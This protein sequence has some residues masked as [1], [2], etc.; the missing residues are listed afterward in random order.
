MGRKIWSKSPTN[1]SISRL[2]P[3]L[4][5]KVCQPCI[6][7]SVYACRLC[8]GV[9]KAG[10]CSHMLGRGWVRSNLFGSIRLP[11]RMGLV[12]RM[13]SVLFRYSC[14][15]VKSDSSSEKTE[16]HP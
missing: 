7:G 2:A 1:S 11:R 10:F 6:W 15:A 12:G 13:K 4:F 9:L 16:G 8:A 14:V 3:S 5:C